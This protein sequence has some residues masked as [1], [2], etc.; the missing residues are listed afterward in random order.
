MLLS[1]VTT[2]PRVRGVTPRSWSDCIRKLGPRLP[3]PRFDV[4]H[5]EVYPCAI[6]FCEGYISRMLDLCYSST[7]GSPRRYSSP[8]RR[9]LACTYPGRRKS[10]RR[11]FG[12]PDDS[13]RGRCTKRHGSPHST[14]PSLTHEQLRRSALYSREATDHRPSLQG[15]PLRCGYGTDVHTRGSHMDA[16]KAS[17]V[18]CNARSNI[19][20]CRS[21][22]KTPRAVV[23]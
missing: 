14:R 3:V 23:P 8:S 22:I 5:K 1:L 7:R 20:R 10:C 12:E 6:L 15:V 19:G 13:G 16:T 2:L 21:S 4:T 9:V 18:S 17:G 11:T